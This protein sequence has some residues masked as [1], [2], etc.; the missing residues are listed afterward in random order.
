MYEPAEPN[1][2]IGNVSPPLAW[3][4]SVD[5]TVALTCATS[6]MRNHGSIMLVNNRSALSLKRNIMKRG[7]YGSSYA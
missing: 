4:L 3:S 1:F 2:T 6:M 7:L 5:G